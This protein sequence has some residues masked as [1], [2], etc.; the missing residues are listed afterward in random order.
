[1]KVWKVPLRLEPQ[2]EGGFTVVLK[3]FRQ[4]ADRTL[5]PAGLP[6]SVSYC[7]RVG[8]M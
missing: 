4:A 5:G 6:W 1:V 8:M 7:V 3:T 2:P